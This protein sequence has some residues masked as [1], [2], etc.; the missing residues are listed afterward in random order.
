MIKWVPTILYPPVFLAAYDGSGSLWP[1]SGSREFL[2]RMSPSVENT[3]LKSHDK[4]CR[5]EN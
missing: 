2:A 5:L 1:S 3:V 4:L